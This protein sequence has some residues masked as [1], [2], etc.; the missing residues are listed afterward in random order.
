MSTVVSDCFTIGSIVAT[1]TCYNEHIEGEVLAFDPQTKM[2]ILKCPSSSGNPKR[3]DVNVVNL[4]LVSDVQVKKEVP[5]TTVPDPPPSLNLHRLNTRVRNAIENKRRLVSA[6]SACL[7]PE[8]QRLFMAIARVI[9]D[10]SW[11][12]QSIR[13]YNQV[14]ITPPY[15]VDNVIGETDSKS[16]NYIR[17]FVE[18]HWREQQARTDPTVPTV[19]Q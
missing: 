16:Y 19:N 12:G 18:R 13:V 2:L 17:K 15:K 5:T 14:T 11:S 8:G 6:L 4:S 9:E 3:H 1:R 7:D 10:V